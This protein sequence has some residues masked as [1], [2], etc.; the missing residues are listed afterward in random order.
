MLKNQI[1]LK[2]IT[3]PCV[4]DSCPALR[5][6]FQKLFCPSEMCCTS[7]RN[8]HHISDGPGALDE[9]EHWRNSCTASLME[10]P[11]YLGFFLVHLMC[12]QARRSVET[13]PSTLPSSEGN[14]GASSTICQGVRQSGHVS[15]DRTTQ[16]AFRDSFAVQ[17]FSNQTEQT[18]SRAVNNRFSYH[19]TAFMSCYL[20]HPLAT[21]FKVTRMNP[22]T[23]SSVFS[24][25]VSIKTWTLK[26]PSLTSFILWERPTEEFYF[27]INEMMLVNYSAMINS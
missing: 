15:A 20:H 5:V 8:S 4:S 9:K 19:P 11:Q 24:V 14:L 10:H 17:M 25:L 21:D 23:A 2:A 13:V 7:D 16:W 22:L 12:D 27:R 26:P 1:L 3:R 6:N 18:S